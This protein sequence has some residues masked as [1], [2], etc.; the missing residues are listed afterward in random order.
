[1][2]PLPEVTDPPV[3]DGRK[4]A[5]GIEAGVKQDVEK[6]VKETG[7]KPAL[8]TI[9]VGEHPPSKLYVKLKH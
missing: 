7:I 9:L 8:A 1:M 4:I 6:F 2:E 3:I 5:Q